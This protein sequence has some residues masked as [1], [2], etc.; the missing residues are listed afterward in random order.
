MPSSKRPRLVPTD[1]WAQLQFRFAWAEQASY[2]LV[3]PVVLFGLTPAERARQTGV[4]ASTV[5]RKADRFDAYGIAG[6]LSTEEPPQSLP[7]ELRQ[8]I[9]ELKAEHAALRPYEIAVICYVRFGRRPSPH[10]VARI[11]AEDPLPIP[12]T[13]RFPLYHEIPD[14]VQRRLAIIRLHAEGWRI[15]RIAEYLQTSRPTVYTTLRRWIAE[16]FR[17]LADQPRAPKRP[18]RKVDLRALATVRQLQQNPELGEFRVHAALKQLGI[19]L[20]PRTCGRILALNRQLYGS[21]GPSPTPAEPHEPKPMPFAAVR[22]HQYW[23]VDVRYLDHQRDDGKIYVIAILDNYSRAILASALSRRQD[24]TAYLIVLYAALRQHGSPEVLVSDSGSIFKAEHALGIYQQLGMAKVQI[25][26]GQAWQSYIE[27]T[28]NIQRR[29]ADWHFRQATT[30]A[31]LQA[32]HDRWVADYNYQVHWA[33]RERPAG[34]RSPAEVLGW[35]KGATH[36]PEQLERA[37]TRRFHRWLDQVGYVRFRHWRI[38]GE[39]SLAKQPAVVWLYGETLTVAFRE[40]PLAQYGVRYGPDERHLDAVTAPVLF[41]TPYRALQPPLWEP[42]PDDW[43]L[44]VR[45]PAVPRRVCR[46]PAGIQAHFP[47]ADAAAGAP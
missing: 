16:Q 23:T 45:M 33:H 6:F 13:R 5:A 37:F 34:R 31:E 7:P 25:D 40:Q 18:P 29:M 2:E 21:A 1:D 22:R 20:S 3:R 38:Y 14:P 17:G 9:V 10:T 19:E 26:K 47:P 8:F 4:S 43:L 27:T 32:A 12:L 46:R 24:L 28:F 39:R 15:S 41:E 36:T 11:V 35:I 44:V 42:G 30:W